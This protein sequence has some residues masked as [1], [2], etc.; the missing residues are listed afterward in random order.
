MGTRVVTVLALLC[1]QISQ[2]LLNE[3]IHG[4]MKVRIN[5]PGRRITRSSAGSAGWGAVCVRE[6]QG[7][8]NGK[9]RP[10]KNCKD[11]PAEA[12]SDKWGGRVY[13]PGGQKGHWPGRRTREEG[14]VSG[15]DERLVVALGLRG[16][17]CFF[18]RKWVCLSFMCSPSHLLPAFFSFLLVPVKQFVWA[19]D[20]GSNGRDKQPITSLSVVCQANCSYSL[21]ETLK[22]LRLWLMQ[23]VME[24]PFR[25]QAT[26]HFQA[27]QLMWQKL[28]NEK[29]NERKKKY[30]WIVCYIF[31]IQ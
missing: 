21:K 5:E 11:E 17:H 8:G 1:P 30:S 26:D 22:L 4:Q 29:M 24:E 3:Q 6:N 14:V 25:K 9:I 31:I 7:G 15:Q 18:W 16:L 2:Y 13:A 23:V 28:P 20:L 27:T 12:E 19:A 10:D